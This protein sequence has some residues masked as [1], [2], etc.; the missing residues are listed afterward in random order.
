MD[1]N[2]IGAF[3]AHARKQKGLTQKALASLLHVTDRAISKW[4]CGKGCPDISLLDNLAKVLD[5]SIMEILKGEK[6][7]EIKQVEDK[8]LIYSMNYADTS[9]K[10]KI[11]NSINIIT[12]TIIILI[13]LLL[14]FYN[15]KINILLNQHYYPNVSYMEYENIFLSVKNNIEII[16]NNQGKYSDKEYETILAFVNNIKDI[17]KYEEIY[18]KEYYTFQ[19]MVDIIESNYVIEMN[20]ELF[21]YIRPLYDI[22][23]KYGINTNIDIY[24][25]DF[26]DSESNLKDFIYN[27]YKYDYVY[28][29]EY[30]KGNFLKGLIYGKYNIYIT[31]L[32]DIIKG[33]GLN[34]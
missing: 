19:D 2:K 6:I 34:V 10:T 4:E 29:F 5:V 23:N 16:K 8:E 22:L 24:C 21:N 14:M 3:I 13:S 31:V 12:I 15:L 26:Y 25:Q 28:D 20:D 17:N 1:Y 32:N 18:N 11:N 27:F 7:E 30:N 33:G 9:I